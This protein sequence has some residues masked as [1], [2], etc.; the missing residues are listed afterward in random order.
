MGLWSEVTLSKIENFKDFSPEFYKPLYLQLSRKIRTLN[1]VKVSNIAYV[2]DGEHGSPQWDKNSG[3]RYV[4][5]EFIGPGF[6]RSGEMKTISARQDAKNKRAR[7]QKNDVLIYSVGA[8]AGLAALAEE[9]IFPANIPRSVA[10]I[11]VINTEIIMPGFLS[12]FLNTK[13]GLFQSTR[14]RAGNSQPVLALEKIK[15][16]EIPS[17]DKEF[18]IKIHKLNEQAYEKRLKAESL[19]IQ[20]HEILEKELRLDKVVHENQKSYEVNF[21]EVIGSHRTDAQC[22]K[23]EYI[24]YEKFLRK[25]GN[26]NY[27][28]DVLNSSIKGKQT[29]TT[30]DGDLEYVSIKDIKEIEVFSNEYCKSSARLRVAQKEDLLLAIT[31]ATI[32]KVGIVTRSNYIAYS[33]D[34]LSLK[35]NNK[36]DPYYLLTV[37]SSPI[38]Q[39]QCKRW[40]TG[41]TNGHLSP[42]DVNKF[43]IPRI[44]E[45]LEHQISNLIQSS[46][47]ASRESEELL[48][49]AKKQVEDLIE[50]VTVH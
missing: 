6:I 46:I 20:A 32:G 47:K 35:V 5:A 27:L 2:T 17:I 40:I 16:F 1:P 10:I 9:R 48:E 12:V 36:I 11:R 14:F 31:G 23:P 43:V 28:R 24:D 7:L 22:Y 50:E 38:G 33:G 29:T 39:S 3:I 44:S 8:Y 34:L 4:T 15:Q 21:S 30:K 26:Y 37:I 25:K 42:L 18:Q 49:K 19:Y 41:S 13:Y 45:E